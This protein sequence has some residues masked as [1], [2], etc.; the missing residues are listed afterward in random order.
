MALKFD[1]NDPWV[2]RTTLFLPWSYLTVSQSSD[3]V[4]GSVFLV[5]VGNANSGNPKLQVEIHINR[6]A[7][8]GFSIRRAGDVSSFGGGA[9]RVRVRVLA[10][11]VS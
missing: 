5:S 8:F 7:K 9:T 2:H 4:S 3:V 10:V 11:K 1:I 6:D